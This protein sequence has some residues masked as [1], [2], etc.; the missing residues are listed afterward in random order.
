ME[1]QH[2]GVDQILRSAGVAQVFGVPQAD[3]QWPEGSDD[4]NGAKLVEAVGVALSLPADYKLNS[5]KFILLQR[6]AREGA[7]ALPLV[8]TTDP[9]SETALLA[10]I[11]QCY[12]WGTSLR[13][14]QQAP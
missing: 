11:S 14:F 6:V 5:T 12:T 8:L 1:K 4:P 13:D 3:A 9:N 2:S 10:L 7:L